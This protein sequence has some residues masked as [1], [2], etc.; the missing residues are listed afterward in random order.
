MNT[1]NL[2]SCI[3]S[4]EKERDNALTHVKTEEELEKVRIDFLGRKGKIAEIMGHLKEMNIEDK[5]TCGPLVNHLKINTQT[6]FDAHLTQLQQQKNVQQKDAHYYFDVTAYHYTELKGTTHIYSTITQQLEDI[7]ISMGYQIV[8]GPEID[9]QYYNFEALNIPANHP[10]RE[11]EDTFFV[12]D[13]SL[14]LRT[15][16]SSVQ[17]RIL[18]T[19]KPPIAVFAPGRV[20]RKEATDQTHD[21]MF[22]QA[23]VVFIDTQVSVAHLLATARTFLQAIFE[24]KDL[25]IRVRPGYFPFVEP[26]IEIDM[27]CLFCTSGCSLCKKTGWIEILGSGMVHPHVLH[28]AHIDPNIYSGFAIGMGIERIAMIKKGITDIRLFHSSKVRFLDQF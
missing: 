25:T 23:E 27:S 20:Y 8:D 16:T 17:A 7:F 21:F 1:K 5:R 18:H 10:A 26:G 22:T 28:A 19:Q 11:E 14:L 3:H 6:L 15:Q 9:N 12:K 24:K 4:L 13:S 2:L